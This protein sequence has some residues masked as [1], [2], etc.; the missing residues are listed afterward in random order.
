MDVAYYSV[1]T[2]EGFTP[3]GEL[4]PCVPGFG[5]KLKNEVLSTPFPARMTLLRIRVNVTWSPGRLIAGQ[6]GMLPQIIQYYVVCWV[7][8]SKQQGL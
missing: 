2:M 5:T 4:V 1:P 6:N 7:V 3:K 8:L